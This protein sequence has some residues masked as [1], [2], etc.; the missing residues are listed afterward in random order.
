MD[1]VIGG[2]YKIVKK[3][4]SGSFGEIHLAVDPITQEEF[5]VKLE[6]AKSKLPQ[7][8]Y[9]VKLYKVLTGGTGIP[10]VHWFGITDNYN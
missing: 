3:I 10:N 7:L 2:K 5:A 9:E 6:S 1:L 8:L 4:G